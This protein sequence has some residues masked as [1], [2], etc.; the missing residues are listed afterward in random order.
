MAVPIPIEQALSALLSARS[1]EKKA[2]RN[3]PCP[4]GSGS[5]Y[6]KRCLS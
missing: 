5:K 1:R 4:C 6:K 2:G 3:D